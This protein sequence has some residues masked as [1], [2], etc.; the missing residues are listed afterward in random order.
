MRSKGHEEEVRSLAPKFCC[1]L[2]PGKGPVT[3][4]PNHKLRDI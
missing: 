2:M 1:S 3:M 4:E